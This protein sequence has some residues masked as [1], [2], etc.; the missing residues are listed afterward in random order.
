MNRIS[1]TLAIDDDEIAL[2]I[3]KWY[4]SKHPLFGNCE[5][6]S[7]PSSALESLEKKMESNTLLPD[8]ILLDLNM[9]VMDGWEVL[10]YLGNNEILKQIP[11]AILTSSIDP[12]DRLR[13]SGNPQI[14]DFIEKP[15]SNGKLDKLAEKLD[16]RKGSKNVS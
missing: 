1:L 12:L 9:P 2:N 14:I 5:T 8:V 3:A 15:H 6:Y 16:A 4:V 11:V 7:S 10:E 13:A